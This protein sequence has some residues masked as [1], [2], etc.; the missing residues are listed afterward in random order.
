MKKI[1]LSSIIAFNVCLASSGFE[2]SEETKL[3]LQSHPELG[4]VSINTN[5][6]VPTNR[7][8]ELSSLLEMDG[9]KITEDYIDEFGNRSKINVC[10]YEKVEQSRSQQLAYIASQDIFSDISTR[11]SNLESIR[12]TAMINKMG[13]FGAAPSKIEI[14]NEYQSSSNKNTVTYMGVAEFANSFYR[15]LLDTPDKS[16]ITSMY[17][18]ALLTA[19]LYEETGESLLSVDRRKCNLK[20]ITSSDLAL[21][22]LNAAYK[23]KNK[24]VHGLLQRFS[25][26]DEQ[27]ISDYMLRNPNVK[28]VF[29]EIKS[30]KRKK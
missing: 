13:E 1:L 29:D 25:K 9:K 15:Y 6:N 7:S 19:F 8:E 20:N 26:G 10:Q 22:L 12:L 21:K 23:T 14:S 2:M 3:L 27:E 17:R 11:N 18:A 4:Q 28:Q 24:R 16:G 30:Y 5:K